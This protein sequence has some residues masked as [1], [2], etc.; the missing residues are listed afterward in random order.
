MSITSF[1][2]FNSLY[3]NLFRDIEKI[4]D[5]IGDRFSIF[6]QAVT[7]FIVGVAVT[8]QFSWELTLVIVIF[9]PLMSGSVIISSLVHDHTQIVIH[10]CLCKS[11]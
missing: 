9:I 3:I 4:H 5:G 10:V 6:I 8:I 2:A 7:T 11:V 1:L